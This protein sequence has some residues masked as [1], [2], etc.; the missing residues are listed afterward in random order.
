ME[1][2]L[3]SIII[4]KHRKN[5]N[6]CWSSQERGKKPP[7]WCCGHGER[8]ELCESRP[9]MVVANKGQ[10]RGME[11]NKV[12]TRAGAT[13]GKKGPSLNRERARTKRR[14]GR[15]G[16]TRMILT[17]RRSGRKGPESWRGKVNTIT[18]LTSY[19]RPRHRRMEEELK[20]RYR[21]GQIQNGKRLHRL[22]FHRQMV[23][24]GMGTGSYAGRREAGDMNSG[25]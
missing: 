2:G 7:I 1:S 4:T 15:K 25:S 10:G 16:L 14:T 11:V 19:V 5:V 12:S 20:I 22:A 17:K 9:A 18:E 21:L 23:A 8:R 24:C 13:Y 3:T 6:A